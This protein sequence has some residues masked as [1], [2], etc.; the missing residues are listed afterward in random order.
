MFGYLFS[1]AKLFQFFKNTVNRICWKNASPRREI[2]VIIAID[3]INVFYLNPPRIKN[4]GLKLRRLVQS[5]AMIHFYFYLIMYSYKQ[6]FRSQGKLG[7][8]M[9]KY[10]TLKIVV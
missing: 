7:K 4:R 1:C 10:F 3:K 2:V 5:R 9:H 6:L 8:Y